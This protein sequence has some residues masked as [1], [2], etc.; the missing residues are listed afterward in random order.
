MQN[1]L[2]KEDKMSIGAKQWLIRMKFNPTFIILITKR[3]KTF[4]ELQR[5]RLQDIQ[6]IFMTENK[7]KMD[8]SANKVSDQCK[9]L[10]SLLHLHKNNS[11]KIR[12]KQ[13]NLHEIQFKNL[14]NE[15]GLNG[16]INDRICDL[17]GTIQIFFRTKLSKK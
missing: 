12:Y 16:K 8:V 15:N 2:R 7:K 5:A 4:D 3:F 9:K 11:E 10:M 14:L 13:T 6:E 1:G 17:F